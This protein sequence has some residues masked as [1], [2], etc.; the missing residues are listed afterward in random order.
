[1]I[2]ITPFR[3]KARRRDWY[4]QL[5]DSNIRK[6]ITRLL[7]ILVSLMACHVIAM[8]YFEGFTV[9]DA[10]WLTITTVTTV[11]YGDISAQTVPG[12]ISTVVFL[13]LAGISLLAQLVGEYIDYRIDRRERMLRGRWRW[14]KMTEHL[15]IINVPNSN[16]DTYLHRLIQQIRITPE[17]EDIAIQLLT[18]D[19]PDGLPIEL[20]EMG[21]VHRSEQVNNLNALLAANAN[22]A[23]YII[24]LADD[25]NDVR[26]DSVSIDVLDHLQEMKAN[27]FIV[28]ECVNDSNK[29]RFKRMGAKAI[30]RPVRAYPEILVRAISAPGSEQILENLFTHQGVHAKRFDV[31]FNNQAWGEVAGKLLSSGVG[32]PLGYMDLENQLVLNPLASERVTS[33]AIF[34]LVN[35]DEDYSLDDVL[36]CI[37]A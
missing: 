2:R 27:A 9:W 32:T 18:P 10:T 4:A 19:Y 24:L 31:P 16:S 1:M 33:K 14:N 25:P 29:S 17:L 8:A 6:R 12:Q 5:T 15:L 35:H 3:W 34:L 11:G 26:A 20:R 23:K 37:K 28:A 13:Y 7:S 22:D 36:R 30:L 21:V